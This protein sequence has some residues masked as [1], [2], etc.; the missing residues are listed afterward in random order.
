MSSSRKQ[1]LK[2]RK[3]ISVYAIAKNEAKHVARWVDCMKEADEI[4]VLDTGSTDDTV[5]L[6]R[7]RG[8]NVAVKKYDEFLFDKARNDSRKLVS[9]DAEIL[10]CLDLDETIAPGWRKV[11]EDAWIAAEEE[12]R[13]PAY[14]EYGIKT[15][16]ENGEI[17]YINK[18]HSPTDGVWVYGIHEA[19]RYDR[20][21]AVQ[22]PPS[23]CLEHHP[24]SQKSRAQYLSMLER[25]VRSTPDSARMRMYYGREL[26]TARRFDE[27][28]AELEKALLLSTRPDSDIDSQWRSVAMYY[29]AKIYDLKCDGRNAELWCLRSVVENSRRDNWYFLAKIYESLNDCIL[30]DKAYAKAASITAR[31]KGYP[32]EPES[33]SALF[34]GRY[35]KNL[36]AIRQFEESLKMAEEAHRMDPEN[37]DYINLLNEIKQKMPRPAVK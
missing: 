37:Q 10:F 36:W 6:L 28:I 3:K 7:E 19:L 25:A 32:D 22:L 20:Q 14:A 13:R 31:S 4:C 27:A 11:L 35:S 34:Y 33:W 5:N 1:N 21:E 30:A 8:V 2:G 17:A 12:G 23:F 29:I 18:I 24:D 16:M 15:N 26:A 9:E